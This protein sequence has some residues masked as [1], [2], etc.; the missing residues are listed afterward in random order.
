MS[1]ISPRKKEDPAP[2]NADTTQVDLLAAQAAQ[3]MKSSAMRLAHVVH[4][5]QSV[6]TRSS[7]VAEVMASIRKDP[8]METEGPAGRERNA[9]FASAVV[10]L[11]AFARQATQTSLEIDS[12]IGAR[13]GTSVSVTPLHRW[14]GPSMR[15][16]HEALRLT[17]ERARQ[18]VSARRSPAVRIAALEREIDAV[19]LEIDKNE[20]VAAS[21]ASAVDKYLHETIRLMR[22]LSGM[23]KSS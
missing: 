6:I 18:S 10:R 20:I 7:V 22:I 1:P 5:S 12:V 8:S 9:M 15:E 3:L 13:R 11:R 14:N 16:V 23:D 2:L 19:L 4:I 17:C 21:A